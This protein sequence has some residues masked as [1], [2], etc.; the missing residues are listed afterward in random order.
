MD[1]ELLVILFLVVAFVIYIIESRL[2]SCKEEVEETT[3]ELIKENDDY[4]K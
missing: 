2:H 1:N 3:S 4:E